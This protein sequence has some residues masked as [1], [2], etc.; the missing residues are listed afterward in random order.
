M[1]QESW[2]SEN[3]PGDFGDFMLEGWGGIV[4]GEWHTRHVRELKLL[5]YVQCDLIHCDPHS[6]IRHVSEN[7]HNSN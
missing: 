5:P 4:C 6:H 7:L 2:G 3:F 1:T